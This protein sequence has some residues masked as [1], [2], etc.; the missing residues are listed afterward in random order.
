MTRDARRLVVFGVV[1]A[2]LAVANAMAV[3]GGWYCPH[4][5]PE[6]EPT[7]TRI[8]EDEPGWNCR[9]MGNRACGPRERFPH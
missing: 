3:T 6:P 5:E 4:P 7:L 1:V 8:H 2:V 9:T